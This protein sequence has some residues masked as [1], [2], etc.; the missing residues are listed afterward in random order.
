MQDEL[1][2]WTRSLLEQAEVAL[3]DIGVV[4][5]AVLLAVLDVR[6]TCLG[7]GGGRAEVAGPPVFV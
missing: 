2:D 3:Q 5:V 4:L 1:R 6:S 7:V